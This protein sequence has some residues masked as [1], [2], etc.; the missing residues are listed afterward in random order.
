MAVSRVAPVALAGLLS[1]CT[2]FQ[3]YDGPPRPSAEVAEVKGSYRIIP[4][5][6]VNF[7]SSNFLLNVDG[8]PAKGLTARVLPGPHLLTFSA[9]TGVVIAGYG[10]GG[11]FSLSPK[12]DCALV[13]VA[14]A[15]HRYALPVWSV[16]VKA[17]P[18][19]GWYTG[20]VGWTDLAPH[21][22]WSAS[23]TMPVVCRNRPVEFCTAAAPCE[24]KTGPMRC[25]QPP[26]QPVGVCV[27]ATP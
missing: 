17:A 1:A 20:V 14:E 21:R 3:A 9:G 5:L 13:A 6:L 15:G 19:G 7:F 12:R 11:A 8:K 10:G 4:L 27:A 26:G 22:W 16:T 2:S 23:G 25:D 24:A 18:E